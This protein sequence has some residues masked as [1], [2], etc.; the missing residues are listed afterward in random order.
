MKHA[1]QALGRL[2]QGQLNKTEAKYQAHLETLRMAGEIAWYKFDCINLRL[3]DRCFYKTDFFVMRAG[4]QLELHEVKGFL[5]DDSQVKLK[6][7][8]GMYPFPVI[9]V[10]WEKGGWTYK[11]I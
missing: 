8:A 6:V 5:T 10:K 11:T 7:I 2:K 1:Y 3:A 9:M 4:G